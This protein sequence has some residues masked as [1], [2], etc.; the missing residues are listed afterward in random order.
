MQ[1]RSLPSLDKK[2]AVVVAADHGITAQ[3]VSAYPSEVTAQMVR[4]FLAGRAAISVLARQAGAELVVVDAGIRERLDD[5]RIIDLRMGAGTA[6]FS[7]GPAMPREQA[8]SAVRRGIELARSVFDADVVACGEM[9]IGNTTA[10]SAVIAALLGAPAGSVTGPGTGLKPASLARKAAVI[11]RALALHRPD[12]E[13][14]IDVLSKVGGFEIAVLAG[15]MIGCAS[16]RRIAVIDG[17]ISSAA[18]L[19]AARLAPGSTQYMV[20]SHLS[21]EPGHILVLRDLGLEPLL[22]L[23]LRL[24][25]A[26]GAALALAILEAA[27]R[28]LSEMAT[29]EE[30]AVSG[31]SD[32][33]E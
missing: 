32:G 16:R 11:H 1:S 19:V 12:R 24:G 9:G 3:G 13:D 20:A 7:V 23:N 2:L 10:A 4:N 6:D 21:T 30:A 25:E 28:L 8:E 31:R 17:L 14:A 26:T 33:A 27:C 22:D 15:I 18:A 5:P 29:F